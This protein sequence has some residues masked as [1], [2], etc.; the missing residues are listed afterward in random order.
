MPFPVLGKSERAWINEFLIGYYSNLLRN[1]ALC[2]L[3]LEDSDRHVLVD[4]SRTFMDNMGQ[5]K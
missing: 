2:Y 3:R 4:V 5:T 1:L